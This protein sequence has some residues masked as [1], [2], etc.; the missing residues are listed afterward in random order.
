MKEQK[1]KF[2]YHRLGK[3]NGDS[4]DNIPPKRPEPNK[5]YESYCSLADQTRESKI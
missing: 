4:A 1:H 3:P 5:R 2:S